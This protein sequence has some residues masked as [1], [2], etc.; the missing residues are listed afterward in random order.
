MF[1]KYR[2]VRKFRH[3]I[4]EAHKKSDYSSESERWFSEQTYMLASG[5]PSEINFNEVFYLNS[6]ADVKKAVENGTIPCGYIHYLTMGYSEARLYSTND[7]YKYC[8]LGPSIGHGIFVPANAKP[9]PRYKPTLSYLPESNNC[10]VLA[11]FVSYLEESLFFAGYKSFFHDMKETMS[12]F[13][14]IFIIV[15][16]GEGEP[17]LLNEFSDNI[18]VI[19]LERV[20]EIEVLPDLIYTFDTETFFQA[21]DIFG[22]SGRIVY[23]CQDYEAGFFP[24]GSLYARSQAAIFRSKNIVF[25]TGFLKDY[26]R[27]KGI[28]CNN[29]NV[30][31]SAPIISPIEGVDSKK[32]RCI[33]FYFRPEP[34]NSRNM[35]ED[36]LSAVNSFCLEHNGYKLFLIGTVATNYSFNINGNEVIVLSKLSSGSYIKLMKEVDLVVSLIYSAHPGVIAYQC[37]A[38]G[39]PTITNTFENRDRESL[40]AISNNL[41]TY[42]PV[43]DELYDILKQSLDMPKGNPNYNGDA[44]KGIRET[45]TLREFNEEILNK[46]KKNERQPFEAKRC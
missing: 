19:S 35:P 43:E 12:L 34:F 5:R 11:I 6:N 1:N 9:K 28:L 30:F 7:I 36:I 23:Y 21:T 46:R 17:G 42:N 38:S 13:D 40:L 33:F 14:A 2:W 25:S 32:R 26:V 4:K 3:L 8:N 29:T 16:N 41:I 31:V 20:Q 10:L 44:Y 15:T 18:K 27:A 39:I 37:A 22:D 45:M 24:F